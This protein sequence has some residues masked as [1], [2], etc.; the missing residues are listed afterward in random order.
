MLGRD[1][2][3][4]LC[5]SSKNRGVGRTLGANPVLWNSQSFKKWNG[6]PTPGVGTL[7]NHW[8]THCSGCVC[9]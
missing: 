6:D 7:G 3:L 5:L 9:E 1:S 4:N 8:E 2:G